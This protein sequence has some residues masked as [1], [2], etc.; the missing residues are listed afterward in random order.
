VPNGNHKGGAN[1]KRNTEVDLVVDIHTPDTKDITEVNVDAI[2]GDVVSVEKET[3]QAK[4]RKRPGKSPKTKTKRLLTSSAKKRKSAMINSIKT[5]HTMKKF[6][7]R[8]CS[9]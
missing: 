4:R 9:A 3:A 2:T 1:W 6:Y 8:F 5:N 7:C